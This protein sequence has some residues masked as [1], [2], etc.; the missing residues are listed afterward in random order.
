MAKDYIKS[1]NEKAERRFFQ[2]EVRAMQPAPVD[3]EDMNEVF[4]VISGYAAKFNSDT[5]IG[6]YW[7]YT[8]RIAPGAFDDVLLQDVRCLFNHDPNYILAR[9]VNGAGTLKLEVDGVG[10]KYTYTTPD[11]SY[12][13]DLAE[14]I[15][16]GN[17]TQS[18]FAFEVAEESWTYGENEGDMD[19]RTIMK[20]KTLYDVS[21]V[22]YPA[23]EDTEVAEE[24]R[25][26]FKNIDARNSNTRNEFTI[27]EAQVLI[28]KNLV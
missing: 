24:S 26:A 22:T 4:P 10:L 17:I 15:A 20:F 9:S 16:L 1:M 5:V 28:N 12:A 25:S 8:E 13:E 19:V 7:K 21:P 14:S 6:C 18:S 11:V 3:G 27:D 23:Y 2:S